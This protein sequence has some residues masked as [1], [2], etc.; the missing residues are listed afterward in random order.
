MAW[1]VH[2]RLPGAGPGGAL[3]RSASRRSRRWSTRTGRAWPAGSPS[4]SPTSPPHARAPCRP[5]RCSPSRTSPTTSVPRSRPGR[6]SSRCTCRSAASTRATRYSRPAWGLL[7]EAGVPVVVHCGQRP[8][9]GRAH[10]PRRL[11][12]GARRPPAAAGGARPRRAARLRGRARPARPP[13]ALH[14]DTTMV[15]TRSPRRSRRCRPTG[16]RGSRTWPTGSCW[17]PTSPTS[18]TP[19]PSRCARSR[20]WAAADD[21]LGAAFLRLGAARRPGPPARPAREKGLTTYN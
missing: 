17:A 3:A 9:A 5:R 6:G 20:A 18:P 12:R 21:R 1:P 15:G 4:G 8:A 7:A 16:R 19:T 13:P 14:L 11:R 10:R 2:Y